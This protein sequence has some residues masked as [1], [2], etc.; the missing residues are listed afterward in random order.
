MPL[1]QSKLFSVAEIQEGVFKVTGRLSATVVRITYVFKEDWTGEP[2][3]FF[4]IVLK[5]EA[6]VREK[7]LPNS[8]EICDALEKEID[9]RGMGLMSYH[10]CRSESEN[11]KMMDKGW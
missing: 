2:S 4:H 8:T 7:I 10:N 6:A 11:M 5:D 3:I 1:L 9:P